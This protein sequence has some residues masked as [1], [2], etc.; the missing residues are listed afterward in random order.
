VPLLPVAG[1]LTAPRG[2]CNLRSLWCCRTHSHARTLCTEFTVSFATVCL[3]MLVLAAE[4]SFVTYSGEYSLGDMESNPFHDAPDA[5]ERG[6]ALFAEGETG[7][8]C[9]AASL[10]ARLSPFFSPP[11]PT[12]PPFPPLSGRV[13][14]AIQ[15]FQSVISKSPDHSEAWKMLV[16]VCLH[17]ELA[18]PK[19]FRDLLNQECVPYICCCP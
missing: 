14:E 8:R 2:E 10:G 3:C 9:A 18:F 19:T 17:R 6:K 16:R 15:A 12:P 13:S 5:F 7:C 4:G 11:N 1:A